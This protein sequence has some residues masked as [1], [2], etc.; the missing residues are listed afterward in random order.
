MRPNGVGVL[1]TLVVVFP[2]LLTPAA[3]Q[4]KH[5]PGGPAPAPHIAAPAPRI[6][7]PAPHISMP[8]PR[9]AA[10]APA[11]R[12]FAAPHLATPHVA[13]PRFVQPHIQPRIAPHIAAPRFTTPNHIATPRIAPHVASPHRI[14]PNV[15]GG[16]STPLA[17]STTPP[18]PKNALT[19]DADNLNR[20]RVTTPSATTP[21]TLGQ[22]GRSTPLARSTAP[23]NALTGDAGNLNRGRVATPD[24]TTPGTVGQGAGTVGQGASARADRTNRN[25]A[26]AN[27]AGPTP[28]LMR[29]RDGRPILRNPAFANLPSRDPANRALARATFS[30]RFAQAGFGRDADRNRDGR[31]RDH[32]HHFGRVLGFI[33]PIF[34]PYAYGDFID[35]TFSP[36]AYDTFWPYAYD[37]VLQGIYGAYAPEYYASGGTAYGDSNGSASAPRAS[38]SA[39]SPR[40][41]ALT[42][43]GTAQVWQVCS[44]QTEGLADFPIERIAQQVQPDQNQQALLDDLRA[45]TAKALDVLRAACP[46]DLP[47]TPTGRLAAMRNRV[48]VMS[49]AVRIVR[50]ALERL[51]QSLSDEQKERFNALDS[52]NVASAAAAGQQVGIAQVCGE[53]GTPTALVPIARIERSLR[54]N[55]AQQAALRELESASAKAADSLRA[56]CPVDQPLTPPGRLAAMERRFDAMLQALDTVQPALVHFYGSLDDEQKAQFNRLDARSA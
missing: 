8:S 15:A 32:R 11:P 47:S 9:I 50:P 49:Q 24:A 38:R 41:A 33:G 14:V 4:V 13:A 12:V 34:W 7:A 56:N 42:P 25:V 1:A 5:G 28:S 39:R 18:T 2:T 31:G 22:G 40:R 52:E 36:Y 45:T 26:G 17:R 10:P 55:D 16:R 37:D 48:E 35:Y 3:A 6:S 53:S 27:L 44:G 54:L 46:S 19:G 21:G 51:Y 20:G 29:G 30:G 23:K 43:G